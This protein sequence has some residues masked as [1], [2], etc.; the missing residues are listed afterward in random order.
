[1]GQEKVWNISNPQG[2][3]SKPHFEKLDNNDTFEKVDKI[4][5][6]EEDLVEGSNKY[7]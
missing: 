7:F 1:M 6:G 2:H 3:E 5:R 4:I